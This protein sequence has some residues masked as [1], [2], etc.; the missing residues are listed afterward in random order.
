MAASADVGVDG[1]GGA[2]PYGFLRRGHVKLTVMRMAAEGRPT[3]E[4]A[5]RFGASVGAV[6]EFK[7]D[8]KAEIAE[9]AADLENEFAGL[10]IADKRARLAEYQRNVAVCDEMMQ[11]ELDKGPGEEIERTNRDGELECVIIGATDPDVVAKM[12]K[13]RD[14]ALRQVAEELG[15]LPSRVRINVTGEKAEMHLDLADALDV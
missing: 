2:K 9:I 11:R 6:N 7:R 15:Q 12:T 10:W 5:A 14:R 1:A 13:A 4:I 3:R 8:F